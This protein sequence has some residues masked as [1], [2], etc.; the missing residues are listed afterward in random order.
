M[1]RQ[2]YRKILTNRVKEKQWGYLA[3][4]VAKLPLVWLG[5]KLKKSLTGPIHAILIVT[6][7]CQLKCQMCDLWQRPLRDKR[8]ELT[9]KQ[10]FAVIDDLATMKTTGI[11]FTGGEPLL[12]QDIFE[13][14]KYAHG[15]GMITHL[16]TNGTLL[17][18]KNVKLLSTSG[19]DAISISL[20]SPIAHIHDKIRGKKGAFEKVLKG[21]G[22]FVQAREKH[23]KNM[24]I[25]INCAISNFNA[26]KIL[27]LIDEIE[28]WGVDSIGFIPVQE[29]GL[30][31]RKNSFNEKL[32]VKTKKEIN[33]T[34]DQLIK[35]KQEKPKL[36]DNTV[37]YLLLMK[38]FFAG[39]PLPIP[40]LAG[41]HTCVID[42]YGDVFPCIPF[43]N[44]NRPFI[45]LKEGGFKKL[46]TS[47]EYQQQR[48][49][50][51]D[52][53]RCFWNCHSEVNLMFSKPKK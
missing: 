31:E 50:I 33:K 11:G 2:E 17:S 43:S 18:Q 42:A 22:L 44:L 25:V 6:Y 29:S 7:R 23:K 53:R 37:S 38:D 14:I 34:I 32:K 49:K 48:D 24:S 3:N 13:L 16:A 26:V 1:M 39:K 5:V 20:D 46:W 9:T 4:Q 41:Y 36:I 21:I 27:E 51:K 45:N 47:P 28:R 12:R 8:K 52:C 30:D 15:K 40:C 10:F 35:I 19:L